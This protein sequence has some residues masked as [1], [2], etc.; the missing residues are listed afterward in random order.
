[1]KF[2]SLNNLYESNI[3]RSRKPTAQCVLRNY[4]TR[5]THI[6]ISHK[7]IAKIS[8]QYTSTNFSLQKKRKKVIEKKTRVIQP[9]TNQANVSISFTRK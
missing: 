7:T 2:K 6:L 1:M 5:L 8:K 4:S 9:S 3:G